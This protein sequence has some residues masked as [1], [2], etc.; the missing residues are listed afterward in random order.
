MKPH[1][2]VMAPFELFELQEQ[3]SGLKKKKIQRNFINTHLYYTLYKTIH[4]L[5]FIEEDLAFVITTKVQ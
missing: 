1:L 2:E 4:K 5:E 3:K